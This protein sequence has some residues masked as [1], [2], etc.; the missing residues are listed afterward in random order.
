MFFAIQTWKSSK[1][2]DLLQNANRVDVDPEISFSV[3]KKQV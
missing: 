3:Y 2:K 1:F